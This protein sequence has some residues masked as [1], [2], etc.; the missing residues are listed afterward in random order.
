MMIQQHAMVE[1]RRLL[2]INRQRMLSI[3]GFKQTHISLL[4]ERKE[5]PELEPELEAGQLRIKEYPTERIGTG[6]RLTKFEVATLISLRAVLLEQN[7]PPMIEIGDEVD[8]NKIAL[9]ELKA[10]RL[11]LNLER[12]RPDGIIVT[13]DPNTMLLPEEVTNLENTLTKNEV[14]KMI[15]TRSDMLRTGSQTTLDLKKIAMVEL[16]S[17][18]LPIR[19]D[20]DGKS[21]NPNKMY[22]PMPTGKGSLSN[23]VVYNIITRRA[24]QLD[25]TVTQNPERTAISELK[26]KKL[27]ISLGDLDPNNMNYAYIDKLETLDDILLKSDVTDL[28]KRRTDNLKSGD[29]YKIDPESIAMM[30]IKSRV[31]PLEIERHDDDGNAIILD[32]NTMIY[33]D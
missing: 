24:A 32:P 33:P 30:E 4:T 15:S 6:N 31:I 28:I 2:E 23:D 19:L 10:G 27:P 13:F 16:K 29:K 11:P 7:A 1:R 17:K 3:P 20:R 9:M 21:L 14:K 12:P 8:P 26:N 5:T 18:Q 25:V 22:L